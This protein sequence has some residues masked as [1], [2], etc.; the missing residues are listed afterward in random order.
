MRSRRPGDGQIRPY[1][2]YAVSSETALALNPPK[3]ALIAE[4]NFVSGPGLIVQVPRSSTQRFSSRSR[5]SI[6]SDSSPRRGRARFIRSVEILRS[7][8]SRQSLI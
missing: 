6:Q 4:S 3:V 1:L 8:R 7:N 2:F 5:K